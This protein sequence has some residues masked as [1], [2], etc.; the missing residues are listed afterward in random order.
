[1]EYRRSTL[2]TSV[3]EPES[4]FTFRVPARRA[5]AAGAPAAEELAAAAAGVEEPSPAAARA[6]SVL[7]MHGALAPE[8]LASPGARNSTEPEHLASPGALASAE[9]APDE[10]TGMVD[11]LT[12]MV[13]V[14]GVTQ[15]ARDVKSFELRA[16]WMDAVDFEPGQY[17]T[18]R[19]PELGLERCYSISSAPFGT[20]T[21]TITVRRRPG[22]PVSTHLHDDV[23][24]GSRLHVDGPYG[25]FSTSAH[26]ASAHLFVAG[27][28]GI[29]PIM[30]MVR[31]LLAAPGESPPDIVLI[32][33]AATPADIVF[34]S[35]LEQLAEV[36]GIRVVT[37]CSR[38]SAAEV[39]AGR[40][41]RIT[42]EVLAEV[43]PGLRDREV[44]VCGPEGYMDAVRDMLHRLGVAADRVHEESFRFGKTLVDR[45]AAAE[46]AGRMG[47][48]VRGTAGPGA[49]RRGA[50]DAL[51]GA[52]VGF[53][54]EFTHTGVRVDCDGDTTVLDAALR[55]GLAMPSSC[56]EGACGTCKSVLVSGEVDMKHNGG[57]RPREIA[58]GKFL[59]CCSTPKSD[60]VVE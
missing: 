2:P 60:L 28:S 10:L 36:P 55:A 22:G 3:K 42:A 17:V 12:G 18:V 44:F 48:D 39:W 29:T 59:P 23:A 14:V 31:S 8:H 58:A 27:G 13:D 41:G 53:S 4:K 16:G 43:V 50:G 6:H 49:T 30:S 11:E 32:H 15:V 25:L 1:M 51:K 56:A 7:A 52:G 37:M 38:D 54:V 19:V 40:R 20:N 21:F 47:R 34:R 46:A 24:V 35:E 45:L 33:N 57:I 26:P 5:R 9:P